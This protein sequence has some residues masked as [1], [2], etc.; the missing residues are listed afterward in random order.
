MSAQKCEICGKSG[1]FSETLGEGNLQRVVHPD[2][3]ATFYHYGANSLPC[4]RTY[5]SPVG[6]KGDKYDPIAGLPSEVMICFE[7]KPEPSLSLLIIDL[8]DNVIIKTERGELDVKLGGVT[9][10]CRTTGLQMTSMH[11]FADVRAAID[12]EKPVPRIERNDPV[13]YRFIHQDNLP[14]D[15]GHIW[16]SQEYNALSELAGKPLP[17]W[18]GGKW[19]VIVNGYLAG[20]WKLPVNIYRYTR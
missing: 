7:D 19:T 9:Y 18:E 10:Q 20:V 5:E 17:I 4:T 8:G 12:G 3:D 1:W 13:G 11:S 2:K 15:A 16:L 14:L 6:E